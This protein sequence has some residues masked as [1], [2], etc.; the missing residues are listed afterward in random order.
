MNSFSQDAAQ[1]CAAGTKA[2]A[3]NQPRKTEQCHRYHSGD[4][5][6]DRANRS[7]RFLS[8]VQVRFSREDEECRATRIAAPNIH[9]ESEYG[10]E[11]SESLR[12]SERLNIADQIPDL[13]WRQSFAA[14]GLGHFQAWHRRSRDTL[15]N[16][17]I[18]RLAIAPP[19][20]HATL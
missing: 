14:L 6:N 3:G 13:I 17:S 19:A 5:P 10:S 4:H 15:G 7:I 8:H 9:C 11:N 20:E 2:E 1:D 18:E 12:F 16:S